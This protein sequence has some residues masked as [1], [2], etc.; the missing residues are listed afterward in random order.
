MRNGKRKVW[1]L[2]KQN[3]KISFMSNAAEFLSNGSNY[4]KEEQSNSELDKCSV[5]AKQ[6]RNPD[7]YLYAE[8]L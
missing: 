7:R 4:D 1:K 3:L 5:R 2:L 6:I 8:K